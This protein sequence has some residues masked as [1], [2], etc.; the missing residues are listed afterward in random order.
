M[1]R[2]KVGREGGRERGGK[3]QEVV[4]GEWAQIVWRNI[5]P[6]AKTAYGTAGH[7]IHLSSHEVALEFVK[8]LSRGHVLSYEFFASFP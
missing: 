7:G 1:E 5:W 6:V 2:G 3:N 4:S 8:Y